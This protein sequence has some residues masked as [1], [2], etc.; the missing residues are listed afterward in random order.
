LN[1][2]VILELAILG[3][4]PSESAAVIVRVCYSSPVPKEEING[5]IRNILKINLFLKYSYL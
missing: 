4:L 1:S 3:M 2:A 5:K